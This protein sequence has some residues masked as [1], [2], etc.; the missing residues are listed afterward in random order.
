[1][2][3]GFFATAVAV[4]FAAS[5]AIPTPSSYVVHEQRTTLPRNWLRSDRVEKDAI[6]PVRI[7]LKQNN[8]HNGEEFLLDVYVTSVLVIHYHLC[9]SLTVS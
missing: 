5:D 2:K 9:A 6:L 8:L 7:G 1:M 4:F 3:S